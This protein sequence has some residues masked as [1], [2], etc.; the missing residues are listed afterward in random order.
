[1]TVYPPP[2]DFA[3]SP[4]RMW[5]ALVNAAIAQAICRTTGKDC[6]IE[7]A[8]HRAGYAIVRHCAVAPHRCLVCTPRATPEHLIS[9]WTLTHTERRV[10]VAKVTAFLDHLHR[11][12]PTLDA[13]A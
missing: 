11:E 7:T 6:R 9:G 4:E 10:L 2:I 13:A 5:D 3:S 1:M 8:W 12:D